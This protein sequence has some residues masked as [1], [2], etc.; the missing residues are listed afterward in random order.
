MGYDD[1]NFDGKD[2]DDEK[3]IRKA[4]LELTKDGIYITIEDVN[5]VDDN[6]VVLDQYTF[7]GSVYVTPGDYVHNKK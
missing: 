3:F 6:Y 1:K 2:T 7:S 4:T 5:K